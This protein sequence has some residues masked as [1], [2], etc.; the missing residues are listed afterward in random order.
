MCMQDGNTAMSL[1]SRDWGKEKLTAFCN[2]KSIKGLKDKKV[3]EYL[4]KVG[5][6]PPA[7]K[8]VYKTKKSREES[9][10]EEEGDSDESGSEEEEEAE[11]EAEPPSKKSRS[12][13]PT[14]I[15]RNTSVESHACAGESHV[16][17]VCPP[18]RHTNTETLA[19]L[20]YHA[21]EVELTDKFDLQALTRLVPSNRKGPWRALPPTSRRPCTKEALG[22]V[23]LNPDSFDYLW[24][25][26]WGMGPPVAQ[27]Q[28]TSPRVCGMITLYKSPYSS[29]HRTL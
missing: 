12:T 9:D 27:L 25:S 17:A 19:N 10:E 1:A 16:H 22:G 11:E 20:C 3:A 2:L 24:E 23:G 14:H 13:D 15:G 4:S 6:M 8:S 21:L 5:K 26:N 18:P 28:S 7:S 29:T